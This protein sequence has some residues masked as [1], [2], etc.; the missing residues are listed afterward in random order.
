MQAAAEASFAKVLK[1]FIAAT[2]REERK[3]RDIS[4]SVKSLVSVLNIHCFFLLQ[5]HGFHL[6][7]SGMKSALRSAWTPP[8]FACV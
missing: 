4:Q 6:E 1:I 3:L 7:S 8:G 2:A 5:V